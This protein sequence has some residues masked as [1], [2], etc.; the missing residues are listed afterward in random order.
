MEDDVYDPLLEEEEDED[1]DEL[2][3]L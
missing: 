3:G 1:S 2:F